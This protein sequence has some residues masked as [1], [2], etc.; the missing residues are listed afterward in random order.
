MKARPHH[1]PFLVNSAVVFLLVVA[2]CGCSKDAVRGEELQVWLRENGMV[3]SVTVNGFHWTC[4][5]RPAVLRALA[6][7]QAIPENEPVSQCVLTVER[8]AGSGGGDVIFDGVG[9]EEEFNVR[10][11]DVAFQYG[12]RIALVSD[13]GTIRCLGAELMYDVGLSRKK[14]LLLTFPISE[15]ELADM[16]D[17]RVIVDEQVFVKSPIEFHLDTQELA[18]MPEVVR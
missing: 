1:L 13:R 18:H 15:K 11:R 2:G 10:M 14:S 17:V 9:S 5:Y 4:S 12:D 6:A 7:G 3:D 16:Q 8:S